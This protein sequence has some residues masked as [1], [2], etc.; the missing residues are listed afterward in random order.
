MGLGM[1]GVVWKPQVDDLARDHS[2]IT[3]DHRGVGESDRGPS[4]RWTMRDM[5]HDVL[6]VLD[7]AGWADAHLVGVSMGG[8]ISQQIAIEAPD[9]VRTLTLIATHPG[10]V[11]LR[12]PTIE[13]VYL[14]AKGAFSPPRKRPAILAELLYP[15]EFLATFDRGS[16]KKNVTE[17]MKNRVTESGNLYADWSTIAAQLAAIAGFDARP[18]LG[19]L[20]MPTLVVRPGRDL[21]V[22]PR[23]SDVL[24]ARIPGAKVLRLDD[25]GHGVTY[26]EARRLN[27]AIREHIAAA[28]AEDAARP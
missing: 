3:L 14:F 9:R 27:A 21:L 5:A 2:L 17:S 11:S 4:R 6:R 16:T 24:A 13:G 12:L 10:G 26:Q 22:Q 28:E 8:M 18:R 23:C 25:A 19:S 7:D 1:R 20:R 15:K